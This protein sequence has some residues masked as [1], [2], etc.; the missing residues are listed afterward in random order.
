MASSP[1]V[2]IFVDSTRPSGNA[3]YTRCTY[4]CIDCQTPQSDWSLALGGSSFPIVLLGMNG[5]IV[6]PLEGGFF[7]RPTQIEQ[8]FDLIE[9]TD[10]FVVEVNDILVPTRLLP[11]EKNRRGDVLRAEINFFR[12]AF[13]FRS[14][15]LA[16]DK[17]LADRERAD[18][19]LFFSREETMVFREWEKNVIAEAKT[20]YLQ[21][22]ALALGWRGRDN[23]PGAPGKNRPPP[24]DIPPFPGRGNFPFK[25]ISTPR[26]PTRQ[27]EGM[28]M[29]G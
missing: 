11:D 10:G 5:I 26:L 21:N 27:N 25:P 29:G 18:S 24:P 7:T 3:I 12:S 28:S 13:A 23:D 8:L 16:E 2:P 19:H 22:R 17:F 14:S 15:R 9:Q 20:Y 4:F 1:T 6:S